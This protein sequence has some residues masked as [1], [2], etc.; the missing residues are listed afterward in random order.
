MQPILDQEKLFFELTKTLMNDKDTSQLNF[1]QMA[2]TT[3]QAFDFM[4]KL[5]GKQDEKML[6]IYLQTCKIELVIQQLIKKI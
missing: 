6:A 1:V 4:K 2:N 3:K 5:L